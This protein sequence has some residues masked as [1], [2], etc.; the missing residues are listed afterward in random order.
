MNQIQKGQYIELQPVGGGNF[1]TQSYPTNFHTFH[2]SITLS[3]NDSPDNYMEVTATQKA[4]LE[5]SDAAYVAPSEEL[6]ASWLAING[7]WA[8]TTPLCRYNAQ[9]GKFGY[10]TTIDDLTADDVRRAL[11]VGVFTGVPSAGQ[12]TAVKTSV[13]LPL[14]QPMLTSFYSLSQAFH[15]NDDIRAVAF[16]NYYGL[17]YRCSDLTYAFVHCKMLQEI[18]GILNVGGCDTAAKLMAFGN[19]VSLQWV[20]LMNVK[21]DV[22]FVNSPKLRVE[23]LAYLVEHA[24]N[25]E[26]ITVTLHADVYTALPDDLVAE[27]AEKQISFATA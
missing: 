25:T 16:H 1:I 11:S 13:I 15:T 12:Y 27:A 6:V 10:G 4:A 24:A 23:C 26:P 20:Q 9:T 5:R 22:S 17:E 18:A 2:T 19:C 14:S 8:S 21:A 7:M 3:A